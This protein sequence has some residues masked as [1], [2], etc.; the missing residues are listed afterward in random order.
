MNRNDHAHN[1]QKSREQF[2]EDRK[3]SEARRPL[4]DQ[5]IV[6]N[7]TRGCFAPLTPLR[8]IRT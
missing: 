5:M 1:L 7:W 8:A 2:C 6:E 3:A 4:I